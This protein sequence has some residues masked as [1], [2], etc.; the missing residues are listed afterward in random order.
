M[1]AT[2]LRSRLMIITGI[3]FMALAFAPIEGRAAWLPIGVVFLVL[4]LRK[5]REA[6]AKT[7]PGDGPAR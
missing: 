4:G 1:A 6:N 5:R 2:Q 3:L 7:P